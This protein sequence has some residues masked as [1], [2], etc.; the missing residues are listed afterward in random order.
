MTTDDETR[1]SSQELG[2]RF[3]LL[4]T[5]AKEYA[6]VVTGLDGKLLCWNTG[7][8]HLMFAIRPTKSLDSIFPASFRPKTFHGKA[9]HELE[10]ALVDGRAVSNCWQIRSNGTRC[11]VRQP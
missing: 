2:E 7:T 11:F 9:R 10:A 1:I 5:D 3:D 6:V 4:A 8:G